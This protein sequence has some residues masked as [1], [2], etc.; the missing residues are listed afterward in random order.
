MLGADFGR[1]KIRVPLVQF[2]F[3]APRNQ[4]VISY[5]VRF[6]RGSTLAAARRFASPIH[7]DRGI[8]DVIAGRSPLR[9]A[10]PRSSPEAPKNHFQPHLEKAVTMP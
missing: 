5:C 8:P 1:L 4:Q 9:L 7:A 3:K 6:R 2:R 10:L